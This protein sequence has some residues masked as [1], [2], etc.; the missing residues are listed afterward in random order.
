MSTFLS[1]TENLHFDYSL[2]VI[3]G[4]LLVSIKAAR[5]Y[6]CYVYRKWLELD[7]NGAIPEKHLGLDEPYA[8]GDGP[9]VVAPAPVEEEIEQE[10]ERWRQENELREF[11]E[12]QLRLVKEQEVLEEEEFVQGSNAYR[13]L[14]SNE[15]V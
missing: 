2:P 13:E 1:P 11:A 12:E 3:N 10:I 4:W 7:P 9:T 8:E 5:R 14:R 15:M 6:D